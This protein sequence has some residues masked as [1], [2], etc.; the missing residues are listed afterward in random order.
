MT[1]EDTSGRLL[2]TV[3]GTG[4]VDAAVPDTLLG[5]PIYV[6]DFAS[7]LGTRGDVTLVDPGA[8]AFGLR[9]EITLEN[10][11]AVHWYEWLTAFRAVMR[12]DCAPLLN[13]AITPKNSGA[14]LSH[15]VTLK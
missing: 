6:S 1:L 14:T 8:I 2:W 13:K 4:S 5:R 9:S 7:K 12:C 11:N 15:A 3:N 10:S